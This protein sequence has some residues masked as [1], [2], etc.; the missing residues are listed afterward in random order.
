M[1]PFSAHLDLGFL[2]DG[3]QA[4]GTELNFMQML[5]FVRTVVRSFHIS[6]HTTRVGLA[7]FSLEAFVIFNFHTYY[8]VNN[9]DQALSNVQWPGT[10][11]PGTYIGRG[12]YFAATPL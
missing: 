11:G 5:N 7:V 2:V 12:E 1:F 8:D 10:D 6:S 3:S 9:V 4:V